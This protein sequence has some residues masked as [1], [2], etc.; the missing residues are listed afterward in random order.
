MTVSKSNPMGNGVVSIDPFA[1][2]AYVP[3]LIF[4]HFSNVLD[5]CYSYYPRRCRTGHI[6]C[7]AMPRRDVSAV[8]FPLRTDTMI[9]KS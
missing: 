6:K 2:A 3:T 7:V 8:P 9:P 4:T 5:A 1:S